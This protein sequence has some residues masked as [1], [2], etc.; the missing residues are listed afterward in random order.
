MIEVSVEA[1]RSVK[2]GAGGEE[3]F[4]K[5]FCWPLFAPWGTCK[6][7][8]A[9][10]SCVNRGLRV[11]RVD[12]DKFLPLLTRWVFINVKVCRRDLT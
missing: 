6:F 10:T 9:D 11:S 2:R 5:I 3:V 7:S 1:T 4:I 8:P 12:L